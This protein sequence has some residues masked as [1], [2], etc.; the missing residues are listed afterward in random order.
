MVLVGR[1][2]ALAADDRGRREA[3]REDARSLAALVRE[4]E[5]SKADAID[6]IVNAGIAFGV[7]EAEIDEILFS[8]F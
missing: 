6:R 2:V 3:L 4:R 5:V 1:A 7:P 8:E